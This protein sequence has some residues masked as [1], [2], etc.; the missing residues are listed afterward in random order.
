MIDLP[1]HVRAAARL[2]TD[3]IL[4]L[5]NIVAVGVGQRR[6][7]GRV[8]GEP[9]VVV[10]V[11]R[12][13]PKEVL[14]LHERVPAMLD[15][16][17]EAVQ[18]DVIEVA[19]PHYV[20]VDTMSYRPVRGGCQIQTTGG[21]GTAG[22]VMYDRR[23]QQIVLL[24]NSHVLTSDSNPLNLP[25]DTSVTQPAGGALIGRSKRL[26][27]IARAP[28]G[29]F[30]YNYFATVDAGIVAVESSIAVDFNVVEISGRH[31]FV[32]LPPSEGLEVVRRG[33]RTQLRTGTVELLD[34]TVIVKASNGDRHRIGPGVFTI[35]SP[36][37]LI[38]AMQGDSGSL[39]VDAAA[40]AAR[41][42][43]F[44]SDEVKGGVTWACEL[45]T[46][47][48][49]LELDT[50]CTG[51]LN[52]LI[53]RAVFRRMVDKWAAALEPAATGGASNALVGEL[54]TKV[55]RFR[56]TYL[57][58]QSGSG[59][60]AALGA[61]LQRLGPDLAHAITRDEDV[62]GLLD[63]AFGEWLIQPT[64]FDM[65]EYRFSSDT[66]ESAAAAFRRMRD[67][68]KNLQDLD[69]LTRVFAE[70]P[71]RSIRELLG[72]TNTHVEA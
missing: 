16:D 19:Q 70:A 38:S 40:G 56:D 14:R 69:L 11:S 18:T 22:A 26:A 4:R 13:L 12:K 57:Q 15:S 55:D 62:T 54:I 44:A 47:M 8:S 51:S 46:V 31:P 2:H 64:V 3:M 28:L 43:V 71:G 34:Q 72:G 21:A 45:A 67:V 48:N 20:D 36:E 50:P 37:L 25:A 5:P 59:A 66:A 60:G 63:R 6:V 30:S 65:L 9:A 24:T 29:E 52:A 41:G 68:C 17:G 33:Y 53:R 32:V 49:I 7:K 27:P 61:A 58:P 10:S 42:L 35:R 23:D 39:V 1:A